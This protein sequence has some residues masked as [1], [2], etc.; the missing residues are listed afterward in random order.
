MFS[1]GQTCF[2]V[3]RFS[4]VKKKERTRNQ[5]FFKQAK[6]KMQNQTFWETDAL[7]GGN[8]C[9]LVP[10][11][12]QSLIGRGMWLCCLSLVTNR[13]PFQWRMSWAFELS[14]R[15]ERREKASNPIFGGINMCMSAIYNQKNGCFFRYYEAISSPFFRPCPRAIGTV[16]CCRAR[17]FLNHCARRGTHF[18]EWQFSN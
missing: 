4:S 12:W 18:P 17:T 16:F 8:P 13:S 7:G 2:H 14:Q 11:R 3:S 6:K 15:G 10:L 9:S 1:S 5:Y